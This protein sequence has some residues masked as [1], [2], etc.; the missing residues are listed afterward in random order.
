MPPLPAAEPA[1][2]A[3]PPEPEPPAA[4][5]P[6]ALL[7]AAA[8][9]RP[10]AP[11]PAA[12]A[13]GCPALPALDALPVP[14]LASRPAAP[15]AP[16]PAFPL[17]PDAP[18][19]SVAPDVPAVEAGAAMPALPTGLFCASG[20]FEPVHAAALLKPESA[21]QNRKNRRRDRIGCANAFSMIATM[22]TWRASSRSDFQRSPAALSRERAVQRGPSPHDS[23]SW[24]AARSRWHAE[25][26]CTARESQSRPSITPEHRQSERRVHQ[27][28]VQRV[29]IRAVKHQ[30]QVGR[31]A[32]GGGDE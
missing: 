29:L 21:S 6:A 17:A 13:F 9:A 30:C 4:P 1:A 15:A 2:P 7:P 10:A 27:H 28:Q 18:V 20:D 26:W 23:G 14:A 31:D 19:G 24:S 11:S 25:V 12:P 22:V 32:G 8:P 3:A 16:P 5:A